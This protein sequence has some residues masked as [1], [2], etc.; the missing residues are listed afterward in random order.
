MKY[1][2]LSIQNFRGIE[3]LEVAELRRVNL[4]VGRNNCGKSSVLEAFLL[5]TGMAQP[6]LAVSLSNVR[7]LLIRNNDNLASMF[8]DQD[9]AVP[10]VIR[11]KLDEQERELQITPIR[12]SPTA[13]QQ[14]PQDIQSVKN[15]AMLASTDVRH[16]SVAGIRFAFQSEGKRGTS[17]LNMGG[18]IVVDPT[19]ADKLR[20]T[21]LRPL[22]VVQPDAMERL[23]VEKRVTPIVKVL[24][25]IE[26]RCTQLVLVGPA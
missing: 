19:F 22:A 7:G 16:Q 4:L 23:V 10:I 24:Q 18:A 3:S 9:V 2:S 26:P 20:G 17:Q 11:G 21:L 1:S 5:L 6:T 15:T 13:V 12:E 25:Q 8:R 14:L